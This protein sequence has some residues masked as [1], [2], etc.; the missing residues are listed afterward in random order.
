MKYWNRRKP[1]QKCIECAGKNWR[2]KKTNPVMPKCYHE[3]RCK[4]KKA[5]YRRLDHYRAK[6]R[7]SHRYLRYRGNKCLL[8]DNLDH[9][10]VHHIVPQCKGGTDDWTNLVTL[11]SSCH[12][13]ISK[14]YGSVGWE[15]KFQEFPSGLQ[16]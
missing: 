1:N 15:S 9:L 8:C 7:E 5:Y 11:C 14:Y 12:G 16:K 13:V 6:A 4:R 10:E 2:D 3:D